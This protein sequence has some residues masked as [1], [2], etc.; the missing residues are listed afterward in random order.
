MKV[1]FVSTRYHPHE[2]GGAEVTVKL[3]AEG[4]VRAGG[5]AVVVT[6]APEGTPQERVLN[7]VRVHYVP[8]FNVFFPH[9]PEHHPAWRKALWQVIEAWNPV[10]ARR[11]TS[12]VEREAPDLIHVHNLLGFTC[13]IWPALARRRLPILQTLHD[14]YAACSNSVM[15]R[16][17]RNCGRRCVHCRVLCWPRVRLSRRL[18]ALTTVSDRLWQRIRPAGLFPNVRMRRVIHNCNADVP[19]AI[20][21]T[22]P[23]PGAPLRIGFLGR[24][25]AIKGPRILLEAARR[26]GE[27]RVQVRLGGSGL[28]DYEASLKQEFEGRLAIFLGRTSPTSFFQDVDILVVPSLVEEASGRVVHEAFGF[29]VPV[30]GVAAGGMTELIRDGWTGFVVPV[31]DVTALEARLRKLLDDPPDWRALSMACLQAA[32][33]FSFGHIF[34]EY[35]AAWRDLLCTSRAAAIP[36][37]GQDI[38]CVIPASAMNA[39]RTAPQ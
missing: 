2:V 14:H 30:L 24:I 34:S 38:Q 36:R 11:L 1:L 15:Y 31:G 19:V 33:G 4:L 3:L 7:G 9:G 20:P 12:I 39:S 28:P 29:G 21:P 6:L 35:S 22:G 16:S 32:A 10:M 13:A 8:L 26:I 27:D 37:T 17:G 23:R 25:E 5:E 18:N